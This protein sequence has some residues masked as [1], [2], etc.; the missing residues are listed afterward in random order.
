MT[1]LMWSPSI[2]S[3]L[4]QCCFYLL[5]ILHCS[6]IWITK[7]CYLTHSNWVHLVQ[8]SV[9]CHVSHLNLQVFKWTKSTYFFAYLIL[10]RGLNMTYMFQFLNRSNWCFLAWYWTYRWNI[11]S[12]WHL[13]HKVSSWNI[14]PRFVLLAVNYISFIF[15]SMHDDIT[16]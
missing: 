7:S 4:E 1:W 16:L 14:T 5:V 3:G 9:P 12:T 2:F 13:G 15:T 8:I 6:S 11:A 10:L